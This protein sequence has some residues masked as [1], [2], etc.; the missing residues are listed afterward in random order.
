MEQKHT[1][2]IE[3]PPVIVVMGHVDHGKSALLDHIRK[4][5]IVEGEAGGITQHISAYEVAHKDKE[6]RTRTITFLDTPGHESFAKMRARG[7]NIADI[8]IL[9]V[10]AEEGVKQQTLEA[11]EAI[12]KSDIPFI[13]AI[14]KIDRPDANV[15][16]TKSS[17]LENG[18][19]LEGLGGDI[20]SVPIS[21]KTGEGVPELLDMMILVADLAELT[22]TLE[23]PAEGAVI[24]AHRDTQKGISATLIIKDGTIRGGMYVVAGESVSPVRIMEDFLGKKIA[25]AH[26]S[27]PI[28]IVGFDSV[29]IAGESF[30]TYEDKKEAEQVA[31][32]YRTLAQ[33]IKSGQ[34]MDD[35]GD[36]HVIPI[37]LR[38]DVAG[39]IEAI[40][41]EIEKIKNDRVTIK[42]VQKNVGNV[43]E[44]DIKT[45]LGN[46]HTLI[47][48]FNVGVD[49]P[50]TELALRS[51]IE[52]HTFDVIYKLAEWLEKT[53]EEQ[54]PKVDTE[55]SAGKATII[56]IFSTT[57][58]KYVIGCRMDSGILKLGSTVQVLRRDNRIGTGVVK[59]LQ[60]Q[61]T[62]VTL[63]ET[64]EFGAQ[65]ESRI[66]LTP[67][68]VLESFIIVK[69]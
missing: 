61:K 32:A 23:K 26:F 45:A 6:G 30:R 25:E 8:A 38:A 43:S 12:K 13:I 9:V 50:A 64:G 62:D 49:N 4:T 44:V 11:Y 29:P 68:D 5:N 56:K 67:H 24:E 7:S 63:V 10:S 3:R 28:G 47:I 65:V 39:S 60:Q 35:V 55:E 27:S 1:T 16:R 42:I 33:E 15:D 37:I 58:N 22:G 41:H 46:E 52:I 20:P 48:G 51:N 40:E 17:L 21:A 19:Y 31:L 14:N 18:I 54:T 53:V 34:P 2:T 59:N 57:K 69:K 36:A 66:E